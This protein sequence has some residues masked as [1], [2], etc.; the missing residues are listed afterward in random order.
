MASRANTP[1]AGKR[2]G[3]ERTSQQADR[4]GTGPRTESQLSPETAKAWEEAVRLLPEIER[5]ATGKVP[6][7]HAED[8]RQNTARKAWETLTKDDAQPPNSV[9]RW[10]YRIAVND[11]LDHVRGVQKRTEVLVE[12][13]DHRTVEP[14]DH[15]PDGMRELHEKAGQMAADLDGLL[16][17]RQAQI[18]ILHQAYGFKAAEVA[19]MLG[20]TT[21]NVRGTSS[22]A[23]AS[24]GTPHKRRT[25]LYRWGLTDK[26]PG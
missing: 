20:T 25:L 9:R 18:V 4:A 11:Y 2:W 3:R 7:P 19:E 21:G 24:L 22:A 15:V 12:S 13:H 26:A 23:L 8:I 6:R 1:R 10:L 14:D 17:P 5:W 16:T